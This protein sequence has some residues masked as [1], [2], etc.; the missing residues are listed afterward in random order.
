VKDDSTL[1][2]VL[3]PLEADVMRA[4]WRA[5]APVSVRDVFAT[6]NKNR[7]ESLAYTT[8]MTVMSRLAEKEIL[9]R[10]AQGRAFLYEAAVP[11]AAAIAVRSLVRDF[12]ESAV[13][14][15]VDEARADP[16]LLRRLE[17]LLREGS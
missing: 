17:R 13:A 3:G 14:Q 11:D 16:K 10:K 6:L 9:R 12:G 8:V 15:F 4:V 1:E 2:K 5:K 7:R